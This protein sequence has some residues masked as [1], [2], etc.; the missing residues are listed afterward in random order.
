MPCWRAGLKER[1]LGTLTKTPFPCLRNPGQKIYFPLI[2]E[3]LGYIKRNNFSLSAGP[4][5]EETN[6]LKTAHQSS[7]LAIM[8]CP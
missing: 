4:V 1:D 2:E 7:A 3:L 6:L 8:P 5:L